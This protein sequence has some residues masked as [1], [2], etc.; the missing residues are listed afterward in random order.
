MRTNKQIEVFFCK[1]TPNNEHL[2]LL[3][4]RIPARGGFWQPL[5]GG[6]EEGETLEEAIKRETFEETGINN[7]IKLIDIDY[8]FTFQEKGKSYIEYVFGI[9]ISAD[10]N[11]KLSYEHD[12]FVWVGKDKA[13]QLLKW[14]DNKEGLCKLCQYLKQA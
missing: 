7:I 9:E 3:M 5:T 1:T 14:P 2:F 6:V 10:T 4:K 8:Q 13:L 12:D 11:I